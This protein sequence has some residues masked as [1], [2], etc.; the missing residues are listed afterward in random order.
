MLTLL[1]NASCE[2]KKKASELKKT[3]TTMAVDTLSIS[4]EAAKI[5]ENSTEKKNL[6]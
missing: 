2:D 6:P 1:S 5:K 4:P 3:I